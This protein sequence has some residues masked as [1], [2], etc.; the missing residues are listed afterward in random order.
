MCTHFF[1]LGSDLSEGRFVLYCHSTLPQSLIYLF[2][3]PTTVS[4]LCR[5]FLVPRLLSVLLLL[6]QVLLLSTVLFNCTTT[7][8]THPSI[9]HSSLSVHS[10]SF[11][12]TVRHLTFLPLTCL[13]SSPNLFMPFFPLGFSS[14]LPSS[15]HASFLSPG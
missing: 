13:S 8:H 4:S 7:T 3:L 11:P 12:F 10:S 5:V 1:P 14:L 2:L 9:S 6:L 15:L